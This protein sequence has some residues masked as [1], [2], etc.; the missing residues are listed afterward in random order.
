MGYTV[1]TKSLPS[2]FTVEVVIDDDAENPAKDWDMVGTMVLWDRC[3]YDFGQKAI[4]RDTLLRTFQRPEQYRAASLSV[5]P[6]RNHDQHLWIQL[7][8]GQRPS[9]HHVLHQGKSDYLSLARKSL[10]KESP[11]KLPSSA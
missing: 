6:L 7:P 8:L 5:R 9:W 11:Q 3:R 4:D 2:G 10:H 1:E